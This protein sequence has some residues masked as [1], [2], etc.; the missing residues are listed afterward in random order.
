MMAEGEVY[1]FNPVC[2]GFSKV[3]FMANINFQLTCLAAATLAGNSW[4]F[5][6]NYIQPKITE[7]SEKWKI[8]KCM[9]A[10][11][12]WNYDHPVSVAS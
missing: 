7:I 5:L 6:N 2:K 8:N 3:K 4:E 11:A 1:S 9:I 12:C 10:N